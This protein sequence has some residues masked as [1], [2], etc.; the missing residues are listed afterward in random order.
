MRKVFIA[1]TAV[2]TLATAG[3]AHAQP[4]A[5]ADII[6]AWDKNGDGVVDKDEWVAAGR[7]A[8]RFD[9]VDANHDGKVTAEEL[10]AAMAKMR[11]Q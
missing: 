9:L 6:K 3:L 4:P 5:P 1:L 7:K 8:E 2:A 11:P 10:G